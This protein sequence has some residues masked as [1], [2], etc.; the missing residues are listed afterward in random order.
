MYAL[1]L[2]NIWI[3]KQVGKLFEY[4][5]P[6]FRQIFFWMCNRQSDFLNGSLVT[7]I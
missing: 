2:Q 1:T 5:W 3:F 7:E 6:I 4:A